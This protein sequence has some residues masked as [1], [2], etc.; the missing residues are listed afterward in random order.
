MK[1]LSRINLTILKSRENLLSNIAERCIIRADQRYDLL[2]CEKWLQELEN[3][4]VK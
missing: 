3:P 4:T 1:Y 2:D